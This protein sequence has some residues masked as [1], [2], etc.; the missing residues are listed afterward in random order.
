[1]EYQRFYGHF[2]TINYRESYDLFAVSGILFNHESPRRG[3]E[4][5]TR[6][7]SLGAARIKLGLA[8]ELRMG[9]LKSARD[10]GFT[11]DYV[12]AIWRML[13]HDKPEDFII[14]TGKTHTVEEL[15][16]IA[17]SHLGLEWRDYVKVDPAFFRPAEVDLLVGDSSKAQR[18][19]GWKPKVDFESLI[20]MMV[21]ADLAFLEQTKGRVPATLSLSS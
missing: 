7:V 19:L 14:A 11:G 20:K 4:F 12:E 6:K 5:V 13:Q 8:K 17:F 16:E 15:V 9:N 18:V 2:I 10:W 21:D 1:M 3:K